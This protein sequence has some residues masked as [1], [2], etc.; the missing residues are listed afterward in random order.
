MRVHEQTVS[1][2]PIESFFSALFGGF[3]GG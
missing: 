3:F 2:G 1:Q